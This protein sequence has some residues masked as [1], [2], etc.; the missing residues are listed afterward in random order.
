MTEERFD[1]VEIPVPGQPH[2]DDERTILSA[3]PVVPLAKIKARV[4][5]RRHWI[6]GSAFAVAMMLGAASALIASYLRLRA[7]PSS[8]SEVTQQQITPQPLPATQSAPSE[9]PVVDPTEEPV[10]PVAA[11][12]PTE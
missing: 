8:G 4:R 2:F 6:L 5:H 12:V 9:S 11:A 3:R 7:T 10:A 1:R